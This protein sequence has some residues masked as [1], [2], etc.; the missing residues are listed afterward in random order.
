MWT[1]KKCSEE[2]ED[3]FDSCWNCQTERSDGHPPAASPITDEPPEKQLFVEDAIAA[4]V[5]STLNQS[6][7]RRAVAVVIAAIGLVLIIIGI[8]SLNSLE[9]QFKRGLG[10]SDEVATILFLVGIPALLG[11]LFFAIATPG[12]KATNHQSNDS[13]DTETRLRRLQ[14]LRQKNLISRAE[15]EQQRKQILNNL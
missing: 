15:Y 2:N 11:G 14:D 12:S 13:T 7:V 9:S 5:S 10:G 3:T 4:S 1:C 6:S 8:A